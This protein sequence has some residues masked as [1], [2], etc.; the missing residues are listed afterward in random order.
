MLVDILAVFLRRQSHLS[1][2]AEAQLVLDLIFKLLVSKN[3]LFECWVTVLELRALPAP[4]L[5]G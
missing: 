4:G 2:V 5:D 1:Q 3:H